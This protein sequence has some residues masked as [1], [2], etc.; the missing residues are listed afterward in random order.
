MDIGG[1]A[2]HQSWSLKR[3]CS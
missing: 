1:S 3:R 2:S